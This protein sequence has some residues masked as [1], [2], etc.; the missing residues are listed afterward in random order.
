MSHLRRR[1][2]LNVW[3]KECGNPLAI[4]VSERWDSAISAYITID[5]TPLRG[6]L[7]MISSHY[8]LTDSSGKILFSLEVQQVVTVRRFKEVM[9]PNR[10]FAE[11]PKFRTTMEFVTQRGTL[12]RMNIDGAE[13][14]QFGSAMESLWKYVN[15]KLDSYQT[16]MCRA[17][18][19]ADVIFVISLLPFEF[20][21]TLAQ[22]VTRS[23]V[24]PIDRLVVVRIDERFQFQIIFRPE[25][26]ADSCRTT[27][28]SAEFDEVSLVKVYSDEVRIIMGDGRTFHLNT[29]P[30]DFA[31]VCKNLFVFF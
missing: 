28:I 4:D 8:I 10:T 3:K 24:V 26:L 25:T 29:I 12:V 7:E 23:S 22:Q 2:T 27:S 9:F 1:A 11:Q 14:V 5:D 30:Y 6:I 19:L 17:Y 13:G 16:M 15:G 21:A 18:Y 20:D 31:N